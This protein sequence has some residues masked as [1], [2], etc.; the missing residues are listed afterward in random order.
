VYKPTMSTNSIL[1]Y[2]GIEPA[3]DL[4]LCLRLLAFE[5]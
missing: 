5:T 4:K 1:S 3:A 2:T